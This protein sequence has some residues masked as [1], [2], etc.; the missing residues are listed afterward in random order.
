MLNGKPAN[1]AISP[2]AGLEKPIQVNGLGHQV[3]HCAAG[4]S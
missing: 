1:K 4:G 2:P 3:S